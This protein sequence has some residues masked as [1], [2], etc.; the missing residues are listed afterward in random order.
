L[1]ENAQAESTEWTEFKPRNT[2]TTQT[3][4][5]KG[6]LCQ[7]F[8]FLRRTGLTQRRK[9]IFLIF[10]PLLGDFASLRLCVKFLGGGA[11]ENRACRQGVWSC[12]LGNDFL[13]G[14]TK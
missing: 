14:L 7:K 2:P 10:E 9:A 11:G 1:G 3:E 12:R 5:P 4:N 6:I 8:G 13:T